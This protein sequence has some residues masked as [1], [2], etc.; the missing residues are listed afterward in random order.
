MFSR[1]VPSNRSG[2]WGTIEIEDRTSEMSQ[3]E[4]MVTNIIRLTV[5][6]SDFGS[7]D[8]VNINGSR[9]GLYDTEK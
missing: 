1:M 5:M 2:D 7:I 3:P 9:S 8:T 4:D 6:K